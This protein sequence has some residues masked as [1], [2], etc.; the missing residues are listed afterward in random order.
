[1]TSFRL[2][3]FWK[4]RVTILKTGVIHRS[5]NHTSPS[6]GPDFVLP[7]IRLAIAEVQPI[8]TPRARRREPP[9]VGQNIPKLVLNTQNCKRCDDLDSIKSGLHHPLA[10]ML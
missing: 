9:F 5:A 1:M 8:K 2:R 7:L 10:A 6:I 4:S 3:A